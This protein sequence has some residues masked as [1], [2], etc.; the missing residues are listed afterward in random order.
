VRHTAVVA[1]LLDDGSWE[2]QGRRLTLPVRIT[3]ASAALATYLVRTSAASRLVE[4]TG[5]SLVSMAGRT[6]LV[7]GF[8]NY[9]AGDLDSYHEVAVALLAR[10][11]GRVGPYVRQMAVTESFTLEAGRALWGLPK[12]LA[13]VELDITG[14]SATC[15]LADQSGALVLTAALRTLPWRLSLTLPGALTVLA[16]HGDTVLVSR[17]RGRMSGIRV[18]FRGQELALSTGHPMAEELRLIGLRQRPIVTLTA[19]HLEFNL[20]AAVATSR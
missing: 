15:R 20:A 2:V 8:I 9:R 19:E 1:T 5:L 16:P 11:R 12:R 3:D 17:I 7:L 18:G 6:P 14:G 4:G 10:H 13:R